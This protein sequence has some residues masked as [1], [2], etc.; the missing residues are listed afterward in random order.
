MAGCPLPVVSLAGE[1]AEV[2]RALLD[3][4]ERDGFFTIVDHG[5]SEADVAE[6][7][8]SARRFLAAPQQVKQATRSAANDNA[9][10]TLGYSS[11]QLTESSFARHVMLVGFD[12]SRMHGCWP[13]EAELPG[14]KKETLLFMHRL[15]D[16]ATRILGLLALALGL[17]QDAWT[18]DM[19]PQDDD[20]GTALSINC[21]PPLPL[22]VDYPEGALRVHQHTDFEV[23]TLLLQD[24]PGLELCPGK[25]SACSS[26]DQPGLRWF[27]ADP[28]AGGITCNLGD[29]LQILT[30]GRLKSTFHRVRLPRAGESR[31]ERMSLAFFSNVGLQT[32]LQGP[33]RAQPPMT[34]S[35]LL[36]RR[37]ERIPL[38]VGEGGVVPPAALAAYQAVVAGPLL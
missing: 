22:G 7:Y 19:R 10:Y 31:G 4:A 27:D 25:H 8:A 32:P 18:R 20:C 28:V 37:K 13:S 9:H 16:I 24:A 30:D 15:H 11:E 29:A 14:W 6:A 5:L 12:N 38:Q 17:E 21:Y 3:A 34:F 35:E 33:S 2:G 26:D 1:D 23:L 36:I